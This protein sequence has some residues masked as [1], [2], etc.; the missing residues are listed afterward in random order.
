MVWPTFGQ[1][2]SNMHAA[3]NAGKNGRTAATGGEAAENRVEN[4]MGMTSELGMAKRKRA[5]EDERSAQES[6]G[7]KL[8]EGWTAMDVLPTKQNEIVRAS[9]SGSIRNQTFADSLVVY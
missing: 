6:C 5:R 7:A 9:V 3:R 4:R 1:S 8:A 2:N